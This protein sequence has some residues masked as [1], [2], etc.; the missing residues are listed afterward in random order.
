[1]LEVIYIHIPKTAGTSILELF[2]RHYSPDGVVSIKR[3]VFTDRPNEPACHV[4]KQEISDRTRVLHGH[5]TYREVKPLSDRQ[6][7]VK[8]I[9]FVR[10]PVRRVVSNYFFFKQRIARGKVDESDLA[11][12][13]ETLLE[14]AQLEASR[15]RMTKFLDGLDIDD[16]FFIG[17][18]ETFEADIKKLCEL[19]KI[20]SEELPMANKNKLFADSEMVVNDHE[21]SE[22]ANLNAED[23]ALYNSILAKKQARTL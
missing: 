14:Y 19:L 21:F 5:F 12:T 6:N 23:M 20:K 9:T 15:N 3:K 17:Q 2:H 16:L 18:V 13:N 10:H 8:L 22:I 1:M 4:L 11:R 7:D